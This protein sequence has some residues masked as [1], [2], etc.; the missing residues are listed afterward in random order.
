MATVTLKGNALK[1][2]VLKMLLT[3]QTTK[4]LVLVMLMV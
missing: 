1:Q 3:Y 4:M 2:K